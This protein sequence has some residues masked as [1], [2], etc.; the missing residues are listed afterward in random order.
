MLSVGVKG[1]TSQ[2]VP[3]RFLVEPSLAKRGVQ[4]APPPALDGREAQVG[5]RWDAA[6]A[7]DRVDEFKESVGPPPR[8]GVEALPDRPQYSRRA[9]GLV[10]N[11]RRRLPYLM[12]RFSGT[13]RG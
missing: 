4:A 3:K 12:W 1:M 5:H 10:H 9:Y 13:L 11:S 2:K 7:Q 6:N 8:A